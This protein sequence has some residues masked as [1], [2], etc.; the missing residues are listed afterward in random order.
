[1]GVEETVSARL[2]EWREGIAVLYLHGVVVVM[3]LV[4]AIWLAIRPSPKLDR[5]AGFVIAALLAFGAVRILVPRRHQAAVV[6]VT[7][8]IMGIVGAMFL[9]LSPG[10]AICTLNG[11]V[12]AAAVFGRRAGFVAL[13]ASTAAFV[14]L[15]VA[16]SSGTL[17]G[18]VDRKVTNPSSLSNWMRIACF[19]AMST[20]LLMVALS[21]VFTRMEQALREAEVSATREREAQ[22]R[23]A[24]ADDRR[25]LAEDVAHEAQRLEAIGRLTGGI[26]HDVNNLLA[27]VLAWTDVLRRQ[28]E[29]PPEGLEHIQAAAT[30]GSQLTRRL[31]TFAKR[32]AYEPLP[33][34]LDAAVA[35]FATI[36]EGVAPDGVRID[37]HR[38]EL[39]AVLADEAEVMQVVLNLSLNAIDAMPDGGALSIR[40]YLVEPA[41]LPE[42]ARSKGAAH[43]A[44]EVRDD[45]IGMDRATLSR[46]LEPEFTTKGSR[47]SG[48]GLSTVKTI[49]D[50]ANGFLLVE[51]EPAKGSVFTVGFPVAGAA[52]NETLPPAS[53]VVGQRAT[54]LLVDRDA[55]TR[56]AASKALRSAGFEVHE[57]S[58]TVRGL[59]IA[60]RQRGELD[61]L[62]LAHPRE[63][64]FIAGF[65]ALYP[66]APVLLW[67]DGVT[68]VDVP[69]ATTADLVE[70]VAGPFDSTA[71]AERARGL[72]ARRRTRSDR[73]THIAS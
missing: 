7:L 6:S 56:N 21:R 47:G 26:A 30:R 14:S 25:R 37:H 9:G 3:P 29:A 72:V 59:A 35:G 2:R 73:P 27:I 34:D 24:E 32:N 57:G 50:Q 53:G 15:G 13:A 64:D 33:V 52:S 42:S 19:L 39:P 38:A 41:E 11:C 18:I 58:D 67:S 55:S 40:T 48:F 49:V 20:G 62:C 16:A 22:A 10:P 17:D 5:S 28:R 8:L 54:V 63:T 45:G 69:E 1:M 43:V 60:R 46:I 65:R 31:L 12:I 23:S 36:L 66:G 4:L 61:L 70:H 44:L 51:S 68:E 71:L